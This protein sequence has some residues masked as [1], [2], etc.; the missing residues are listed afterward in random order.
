MTIRLDTNALTPLL[1][2]DN[3]AFGISRIDNAKNADA[4]YFCC[5]NPSDGAAASRNHR[6]QR[7]VHIVNGKCN[8][9]EPALVRDRHAEFN[10]FVIAENL[11]RRAI[12]AIAGQA[13]M[14]AGKMRVSDGVHAV[15]PGARQIALRAF[16]LAS[17][18][19]NVKTNQSFPVSGNQICVNVLGLDWHCFLLWY[20]F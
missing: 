8:V 9:S 20:S 2:F 12:L 13:Q 7:L 16:R 6:L 1:Q 15:K 17:E 11:E 4:I 5:G 3:I 18:Y 14:N 19:V 10:E